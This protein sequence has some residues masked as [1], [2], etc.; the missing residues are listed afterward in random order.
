MACTITAPTLNA[1]NDL[2]GGAKQIELA[3][4]AEDFDPVTATWTPIPTLVN[5]VY[6]KE[7]PTVNADNQTSFFTHEVYFKINGID[8][9]TGFGNLVRA[10]VVARITTY[11]DATLVYGEEQGLN[12][13]AG[14]R[15]TGQNMEDMPGSLMTYSGVSSVE[16]TYT[17]A[18]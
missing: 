2:Q 5:S 15:N 4:W 12:Y 6:G 17:A 9:F 8:N 3:P 16:A 14:E 7:T 18:P 1:C 10:K 13:S 11:T